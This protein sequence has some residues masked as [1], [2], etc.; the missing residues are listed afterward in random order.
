M[1]DMEENVWVMNADTERGFFSFFSTSSSCI[2][3]TTDNVAWQYLQKTYHVLYVA[4]TDGKTFKL[5][6]L[7]LIIIKILCQSTCIQPAESILLAPFMFR[8]DHQCTHKW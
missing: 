8:Y 3:D 4:S 5:A 2:Y 7:Y 1:C 6:K